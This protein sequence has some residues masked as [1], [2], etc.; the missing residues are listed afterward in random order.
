MKVF[1]KASWIWRHDPA[2]ADE[3]CDFLSC[4]S[5]KAGERYT[6]ALSVDTNYTVWL[7]GELAAFGQYADYPYDKIYDLVDIT[8]YVK[9]GENRMVVTVWYNGIGSATYCVGEAG[10]IYELRDGGDNLVDC[11]GE[12]TLCRLSRDYASWKAQLITCQLGA[13]FHYDMNADDGFRASGGE[14][15][16]P[17]RVMED[18]SK[19]L[20]LRPNKKLKLLERLPATL[21]Q[22]GSFT[23]TS[24]PS[25]VGEA[26]QRAAITSADLAEWCWN[27]NRTHPVMPTRLSL[28]ADAA[29]ATGLYFIVDL[30]E[31]TAG[32]LDF[33][34]EVP[35][36]C[37]MDVGW[38]EHLDD[39]RCR[40]AIDS[41]RF[42][43]DIQLK[44]GRNTYLHTF[45]RFG[46][47]YLQ[48]F[49]HTNE[50]MIHYAG[51]RPT[52]Y[53]FKVKAYRSGNLLRDTIYQVC[54]NTLLHCYHEHYEDCPWREQALYT[55]DSRNQML[56]GYY[57]LEEY[58]APRAALELISHGLR[59]DGILALNYPCGSD[60][61]IPTFSC[62][63][64]MQ[65][66]E[67]IRYTGDTSLAVAH[68]GLLRALMD[69]FMSRMQPEGVLENFYGGKGE[70]WNFYE[71]SDT[72]HG[73]FGEMQRRLEAPLNAFVSIAMQ[74]FAK[75][76]SAIGKHEDA[77]EYAARAQALN[78]AIAK[79]FYN[80]E[81]KLFESFDNIH[82]GV[83]T[84]LTQA[85]CTLCG[86]A[87][88]LDMS[89]I[90]PVLATNGREGGAI[91]NTLSMNGFR[92][93]ALLSVDREKYAPVILD[94]IDRDY[95][96]MLRNGATTFWE[97]AV[98]ADDFE[99]AGSLCHGWSALPI[100]YYELLYSR[101]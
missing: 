87:E 49:I 55:L 54:Q 63:Y 64:F 99:G 68:E 4:F 34:I 43:C 91:P 23:Y 27:W 86:A 39:G 62:A 30:G 40:T 45:R 74:A 32:F 83:Y 94:E 28:Q 41:R 88:G 56:C 44:A 6:L 51:L 98:G 15:F 57:A 67:Y 97:T 72:M 36:A 82:R 46:C 71:W 92:F 96:S 84:T 3:V 2:R 90:L 19:S 21:C 70:F 65:M 25:D 81:T 69:T 48:F 20:T 47:R 61:P 101:G 89:A 1:E 85:L 52:V 31:E 7:N 8:P 18:R 10:L 22:C 59:D 26:M 80:P 76:L 73:P 29:D 37:R 33:D 53:P 12:H 14:G 77:A 35:E 24:D 58:E 95:L 9:A 78:A 100:Y 42:F 5:A 60:A 93:D 50:A 75:I 79:V 11:S 17:S 66:E 16:A 13:T 38:G